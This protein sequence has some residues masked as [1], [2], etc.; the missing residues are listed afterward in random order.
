MKVII[1]FIDAMRDVK[2]STCHVANKSIMKYS[3]TNANEMENY[4][5]L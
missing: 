4:A 2:D 3:Q 1:G 5:N